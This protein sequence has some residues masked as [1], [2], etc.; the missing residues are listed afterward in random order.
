MVAAVM[1]LHQGFVAHQ[2]YLW[3]ESFCPG[4]V[5]PA[6]PC[7]SDVASIGPEECVCPYALCDFQFERRFRVFHDFHRQY[8]IKSR[9]ELGDIPI[10]AVIRHT[11]R[12]LLPEVDKKAI[13]QDC[14][15]S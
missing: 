8:V 15:Y 9:P 1:P 11:T 12:L 6:Y 14:F 3:I 4:I 2:F 7:V 13:E 5:S 10:E